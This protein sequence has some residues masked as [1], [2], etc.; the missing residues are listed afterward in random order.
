SVTACG[1]DDVL[2]PVAPR[3]RHRPCDAVPWQ[4][5]VPELGARLEIERSEG[6]I[7]RR[8]DEDQP[9]GRR[10]RPAHVRHARW[11][12]QFAWN[13]EGTLI[14]RRAQRVAP[15]DL[16]RRQIEGCDVPVRRRLTWH[17]GWRHKRSDELQ[18]RRAVRRSTEEESSLADA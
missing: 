1:N 17:K 4:I 6:R 14:A 3:V 15:D 12:R 2:T 16:A 10:H 11:N 13:A 9:A 8:G 5:I 7:R 18:I